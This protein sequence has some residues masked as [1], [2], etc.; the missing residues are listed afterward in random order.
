MPVAPWPSIAN[1]ATPASASSPRQ[2]MTKT[3]P[4]CARARSIIALDKYA[5]TASAE[6][7]KKLT[8]EINTSLKAGGSL[9]DAA[10]KRSIP[11]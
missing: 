6:D 4:A 9:D 1:M 7:L 5:L 11:F 2:R 10:T 8:D 3:L